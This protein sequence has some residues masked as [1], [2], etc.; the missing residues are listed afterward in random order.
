[1]SGFSEETAPYG[2]P[3]GPAMTK[4]EFLR[5]VQGREGKYE[6]KDGRVVMQAGGTKRHNR[7][8]KSFIAALDQRLDPAIWSTW[9]TDVAVEIGDDIRYPDVMVERNAG[10]DSALSSERP[11]VLVEVLSPSSVGRDMN[12]KLA[13]YTSLASLECYIVAS[14]DEAICWVWQRA[15]ESRAF[16]PKPDEIKG[17]EAAIGITALSISL[18]IAEV[19]KGIS[20]A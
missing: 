6:L 9:I 4:A 20:P 12:L 14:Q 7:I 2:A 1:M 15:G 10:D 3:Q 8:S 11:V 5:W 16:P 19:Y 18:P 17:Q 13:E